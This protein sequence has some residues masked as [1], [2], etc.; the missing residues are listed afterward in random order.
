MRPQRSNS[1]PYWVEI[2]QERVQY[3]KTHRQTAIDLSDYDSADLHQ[4][5]VEEL[6][7]ILNE[8]GVEEEE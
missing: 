8:V 1:F 5:V 3:H 2:L 4:A 7:Y 6:L